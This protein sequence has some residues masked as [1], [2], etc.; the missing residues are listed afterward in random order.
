MGRGEELF[1]ALPER[2]GITSNG[3]RTR[4][5]N[6]RAVPLADIGVGWADQRCA[7]GAGTRTMKTFYSVL[8][9]ALGPTATAQPTFIRTYG[10]LPSVRDV[11]A[12]ATGHLVVA[13]VA[14]DSVSYLLCM[15]RSGD[16]SWMRRYTG[17]GNP[18]GGSDLHPCVQNKF[19]AV[20]SAPD[21]K[22]VVVGEA[23]G[24][25]SIQAAVSCFDSL[26]TW[27][28]GQ[29]FGSELHNEGLEYASAGNDNTVIVA[30]TGPDLLFDH[31]ILLRY[32]VDTEAFI[33]GVRM[34]SGITTRPKSIDLGPDGNVLMTTGQ[35]GDQVMKLTPDL[36]P[37]WR[38]S[39]ANFSPALIRGVAN[40]STVVAS[41]T[42][43]AWV[44]PSGTPMWVNELA[45]NGVIRDIAVRPDGRIL[46]IGLSEDGYSWLVELDSAGSVQWVRRYGNDEEGIILGWIELL[47]D[48]SAF[49][50]GYNSSTDLLHVVAVDQNGELS[51][52]SFP[53]LSA[54]VSPFVA[55]LSDTLPTFSYAQ[56]SN[57]GELQQVGTVSSVSQQEACGSVGSTMSYAPINFGQEVMPNPMSDHAR[58]IFNR[59]LP[60]GAP[61]ELVNVNGRVVRILYGT[62]SRELVIER[63]DMAT[64]IYTIR[65]GGGTGRS[66]MRILVR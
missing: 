43:I 54:D 7:I 23:N 28:W 62:G 40:G 18:Y 58:V 55:V 45:T 60:V 39:W 26:G 1:S 65:A 34:L 66:T 47:P 15:D 36:A 8:L 48:G 10:G 52:C 20:T 64:G 6:E 12:T 35:F 21:G 33:G 56:N 17:L 63:G 14:S 27:L 44:T 25:L 30:G 31:V 22:L 3:D 16:V 51:D 41:D 59:P 5:Y 50:I 9:F 46:A 4:D 61:I 37:I 29:T 19:R 49:L 57:L 11:V 53:S 32:A 24:S 2:N 38:L 13:G 42:V